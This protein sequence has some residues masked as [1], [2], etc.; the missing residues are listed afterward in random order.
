MN[1]IKIFLLKDLK[2]EF[3]E[4]AN[5]FYMLVLLS[6][7][8]LIITTYFKHE[9]PLNLYFLIF[10][11]IHFFFIKEFLDKKLEPQMI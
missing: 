2:V 1:L 6:T 7:F 11:I 9:N 5:L 8:T 10:L 3:K 4:K